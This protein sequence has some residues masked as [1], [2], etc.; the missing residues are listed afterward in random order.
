MNSDARDATL[1]TGERLQVVHLTHYRYQ[2]PITLEPHRLVLRPREGHDLRVERHELVVTPE[3]RRVWTRDIFGNLVAR[4]HFPPEPVEEL[5]IESRLVLRRFPHEPGPP[6]DAESH[7][8][9]PL[10]YDPL[11]HAIVTAYLTP[12]YPEEDAAISEWTASLA[13]VG[14]FPDLE[15]FVGHVTEKIHD[16]I[17]YRRREEKGVQSPANTLTL[18]SGSCRDM[19]N[20]A[21][22]VFRH[23]GIAARFASG[24]LDCPATRAAQGSTHAWVEVYLPQH[25]WKGFDPT[26]GRAC[27]HRHI[28]IGTSHHPRGVMPVSGRFFGPA[29]AFRDLAV[30]VTFTHAPNQQP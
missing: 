19:A 28:V 9:E 6:E 10:E 23:A 18:R 12:V 15:T 4:L 20:L 25:G 8:L 11:E 26:T 24:Y 30:T 3:A 16:F 22:E 5:V 27:D 14:D 21:M 29:N 17:G 2:F 13:P 7:P 1:R